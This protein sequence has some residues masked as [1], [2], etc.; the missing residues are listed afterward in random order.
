[1]EKGRVAAK[2][3]FMRCN[4][5]SEWKK[6]WGDDPRVAQAMALLDQVASE[7]S[8]DLNSPRAADPKQAAAYEKRLEQFAQLRAGALYYPY[9]ATGRGNGPWVELADGSVKLDFICG[10]GVHGAGHGD[11][12][13]RARGVEASLLDT[14]MQG[15]LQQHNACV[16]LCQKLVNLARESGA[17]IEHVTLST[18]G[19]MSNENALKLAFHQKPGR[20]RVIAF[21]HCFAGRTLALSQL[22]DKA[23]YR[24]GL[25]TTVNVDYLPFFDS[26]D[27]RGSTSRALVALEAILA[28]YPQ[29]H[30]ALWLELVQGEGGY[31]VGDSYF[32]R[33]ICERAR[34][35]GLAVIFD[36]VQTF[37]R[38]TRPFA[39]QHF[40]LDDLADIVTIGKITQ[41]CATLYTANYR[42]GPGLI[43]QTFTAGTWEILA[44]MEVLDRLVGG[45]HFG[46]AGRNAQIFERFKA[47]FERIAKAYP[48]TIHGPWGV[49]GMLA[50]TPLEGTAD[51][52]KRFAQLCY[53]EGLMGFIAGSQPTRVRFLP[54]L[55]IVTDEQI[56][57]GLSLLERAVVKLMQP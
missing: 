10:I 1:M 48:R 15:N 50:V 11:R 9:L 42:P 40:L 3:A 38:T 6:P 29:Q 28:R 14:V 41:A 35:A 34:A 36:E 7:M 39:F 20:G 24:V 56:D 2:I 8:G 4:M 18:S 52:A 53:D 44:A 13:L 54:P 43:S 5:S 32:L 47:G 21:E 49:G 46:A 51:Q 26:Q 25:P 22:T 19:A 23:A 12:G 37:G 27:P 55:L 17:A 16:D 31:N 33:A 30:A 45:G 57:L